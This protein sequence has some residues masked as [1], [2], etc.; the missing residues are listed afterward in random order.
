MSGAA[1]PIGE[2]ATHVLWKKGGGYYAVPKASADPDP[3][4][5]D[6]AASP[7]GVVAAE[8]EAALREKLAVADAWANSRGIFDEREHQ[9]KHGSHLRADSALGEPAKTPA[10]RRRAILR[11]DGEVFAVEA[12]ALAEAIDAPVAWS[13]VKRRAKAFVKR[14]IL[15]RP[16]P[17]DPLAAEAVA[18]AAGAL[19]RARV[20]DIRSEGATPEMIRVIGNYNIVRF[21]WVYYG[22]PHGVPIDW[23]SPERKSTAGLIWDRDLREVVRRVQQATGY[24]P[25]Q[26]TRRIDARGTGPAEVANLEPKLVGTLNGYNIVDYEGWFY[27]IPQSLGAIDLAETDVLGFAGVFR[28]VSRDVIENEIAERARAAGAA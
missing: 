12:D 22:V 6:P 17:P 8:S 26:R 14:A 9:R 25:P 27:G 15:G 23:N 5:I 10:A 24:V 21:D 2:T 28:D 18:G 19:S 16:G 11:V 20:M 7:P 4:A 3:A 13:D 1:A